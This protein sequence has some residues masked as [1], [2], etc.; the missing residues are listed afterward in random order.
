MLVSRHDDLVQRDVY[1]I[2]KIYF[3]SCTPPGFMIAKV[4]KIMYTD[5][6]YVFSWS[7]LFEI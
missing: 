7:F 4:N 2:F 1:F 5:N 3:I 6:V